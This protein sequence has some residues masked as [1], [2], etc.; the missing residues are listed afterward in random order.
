MAF[1]LHNFPQNADTSQPKFYPRGGIYVDDHLQRFFLDLELL[2]IEH[3]DVVCIFF[4]H[5]FKA[6]ESTWYFGLPTNS[7]TNWDT[8]ERLFKGNFGIQ[9]TT[10][11]LMKELLALRMDKKEKVQDFSQS[12]AA[13]LNNFSATI[14]PIE[15][16]LMEYYTSTLSPY[17]AMFVKRSVIPSLA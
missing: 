11:T 1:P 6:K 9:R 13:H 8:F 10:T 16:T 17:M 5:T 3:E 15:E 14:K 7:I 2:A 12:F 4:P